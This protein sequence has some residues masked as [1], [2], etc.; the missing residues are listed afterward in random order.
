MT[1]LFKQLPIAEKLWADH[2]DPNNYTIESKAIIK[3]KCENGHIYKKAINK[4]ANNQECPICRQQNNR[5]TNNPKAVEMWDYEKNEEDISKATLKSIKSYWWKCANGHSFR[6]QCFRFIESNGEC[7]Y[8]NMDTID[9]HPELMKQFDLENNPDIDIH[10]TSCNSKKIAN[11]KCKKCGYTWKAQISSRHMGANHCPCCEEKTVIMPGF[12]DIFTLYPE[13]KADFND[14]FDP[15][16]EGISSLKPAKWRC[17]VCGYEWQTALGARVADGK[18]R[19]CPACIGTVRTKSFAEQYPELKQYYSESNPVPLEE[20]TTGQ[21]HKKKFIWKCDKHGEFEQYLSTMIR[22]LKTEFK[23]CPYCAGKKVKLEDSFGYNH[24]E[25]VDEYSSK[26]KEDIFNVSLSSGK[27]ALWHCP[28]C[29]NEWKTSFDTRH[30]GFGYCKKCFPHS[31]YKRMLIDERP[32]LEKYYKG[33]RPFSSYS[34][35]SN[36]E[37]EW[38]CEE[39]HRF[40]RII[41]NVSRDKGFKCPICDGVKLE[42]GVND[43]ASNYPELLEEWSLNNERKPNEIVKSSNLHAKWVCKKCGYEYQAKIQDKINGYTCPVCDDRT[44]AEGYNDLRTTHPELAKEY[45]K[46]NERDV[47]TIRKNLDVYA[48]WTC[49]ECNGNYSYLIKDREVGDNSCPYC[50]NKRVLKGFND[51][52]TLRPDIAKMFTTNNDKKPSELLPTSAYYAHVKCPTCGDEYTGIVKEIVDGSRTCPCC[53][54]RK[55]VKGVNDLKTIH[56]ELEPYWS[57]KNP[58]M[59]EV[60]STATSGFSW[61]CHECGGSHKA[62]IEEHLENKDTCPYCENKKVLP[63]FNDLKTT[64]P[65]LVEKWSSNNNRRITEFMSNNT[66]N[67]LWKCDICNGEYERTINGMVNDDTCPYCENKKVLGGFNDLKTTHPHVA[68]EW[69]IENYILGIGGPE[70]YKSDSTKRVYWKCSKCGTR[71]KMPIDDRVIKDKR[72]H[73]PC[74]KCAGR[75]K[76]ILKL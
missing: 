30:R 39:G 32:D 65:H 1:K 5:L 57:D 18:V 35:L 33:D 72:G 34:F 21:Q 40:K 71:Y 48:L 28:K 63:G 24:P 27:K 41:Y 55:L 4:F 20:V 44:T 69:G 56:P 46:N 38:L 14:T 31:K 12:N 45:S 22:G 3:W 43:L 42:A 50:Q 19:N 64:H 73:E 62:T 70:N 49:P 8:C 17:H 59:D 6:R 25:L 15:S 74:W 51:L 60:L 16:T 26:N 53:E 75:M 52:E 37:V 47:T 29:E 2:K 9:K 36:E 10:H 66:Y 11:W 7:P 76:N 13:L 68:K 23:G 67:A 61:I 54:N 58:P